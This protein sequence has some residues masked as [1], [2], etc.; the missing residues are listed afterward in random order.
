MVGLRAEGTRGSIDLQVGCDDRVGGGVD[1]FEL[2]GEYSL[3]VVQAL[4]GQQFNSAFSEGE[5]WLG[6]AIHIAI[7]ELSIAIEYLE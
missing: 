3:S 5:G 1:G 7:V 6:N 4:H 2:L